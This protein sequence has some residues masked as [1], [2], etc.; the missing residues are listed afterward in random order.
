VHEDRG[1]RDVDVVV[2]YI[3]RVA[4][5]APYEMVRQRIIE[6]A[7][8]MEEPMASAEQQLVEKGI[9]K[10]TRATL[11]RQLR[12]RFGPLSPALE[13]RLERAT[14]A[15]LDRWVERI[16]TATQLDEVFDDASV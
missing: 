8:A 10:G 1:H 6:V 15:E 11:A 13:Q 14:A 3:L 12:A 16:L 7:P 4:G 5:E 9:E 2:R